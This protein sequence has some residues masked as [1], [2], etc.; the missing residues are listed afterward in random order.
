MNLAT[1]LTESPKFTTSGKCG[2]FRWEKYPRVNKI[3]IFAGGDTCSILEFF[4]GH[5]KPMWIVSYYSKLN[6]CVF[7]LTAVVFS[8]QKPLYTFHPSHVAISTKRHFVY[9]LVTSYTHVEISDCSKTG[10]LQTKKIR[11]RERN[12]LHT[13][14]FCCLHNLSVML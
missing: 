6:Y 12:Y 11:K 4:Q 13:I 1:G 7:Q 8:C 3:N 2:A 5:N 9:V 10:V 14:M